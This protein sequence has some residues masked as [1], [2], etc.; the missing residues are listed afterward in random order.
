MR[1]ID[2]LQFSW[3]AM[4][5]SILA[6]G[7]WLI[8]SPLGVNYWPLFFSCMSAIDCMKCTLYLWPPSVIHGHS[9]VIGPS[10]HWIFLV[11]GSHVCILLYL[12]CS[13]CMWYTQ[14]EQLL[15]WCQCGFV[16]CMWN[17]TRGARTMYRECYQCSLFISRAMCFIQNCEA[18][19]SR[20]Y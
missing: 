12:R 20:N 8:P 10:G 1:N 7:C 11:I 13:K 5:C 16:G 4:I 9:T 6:R 19:Y 3:C 2:N 18:C 17:S 15:I 14:R